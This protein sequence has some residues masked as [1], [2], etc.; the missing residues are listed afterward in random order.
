MNILHVAQIEIGRETGM[1]RVAWHWRR[2]F[3]AAGHRFLHLGRR[4]AGTEVHPALYP[5][6]VARAARRLQS[7]PDLV[8]AHEPAAAALVGGA[9]P[10]VVFSHGVERRGWAEG[11]RHRRLSGERMRARSRLTYPL[12][13]LLPC[14]RG[15]RRADGVLVLNRQDLAY[16]LDRYGRSADDTFLYR[17][18]VEPTGL[19]EKHQP[20]GP[21]VLLFMGSWLPRKGGRTLGEAASRLSAE[22]ADVHFLLAGTGVSAAAVRAGFPAALHSRIEVVPSFAPGEEE[23]LL[24]R[25]TLFILPSFFEGQPLALLQAMA[26]GRCVIASD[27]CGQ[28]DL[29]EHGVNGLLHPPGDAACLAAAITGSLADPVL[30]QRLGAAARRSVADR[31]WAAVA[32]EVVGFVEKVHA[33]VVGSAGEAA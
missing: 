16:C 26:A 23:E 12:W 17:N 5:L 24:A 29:V 4:P 20:S 9:L 18:G 27:T 14:D 10:A 13:R 25:A 22:Q 19:T 1:G 33:R 2:A 30:R 6:A 28:R 32:A 21:P 11:L 8:L 3:E 15:L 31:S 7:R